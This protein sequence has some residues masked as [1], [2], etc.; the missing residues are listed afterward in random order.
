[1]YCEPCSAFGAGGGKN[2]DGISGQKTFN[3]EVEVLLQRGTTFRITKIEQANGKW[4][5]DMDV[6]GQTY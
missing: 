6:I 2:W 3:Y 5:I 4:Y 1:M